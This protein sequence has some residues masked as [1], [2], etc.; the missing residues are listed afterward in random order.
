M[1]KTIIA[2][3]IAL[4]ALA[5]VP[6]LAVPVSTSTAMEQPSSV[7]DV[8]Y[9]RGDRGW[10]PNRRHWDGPGRGYGRRFHGPPPHAR[11]Y[12]RRS[13]DRGYYRY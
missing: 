5:T 3:A 4:G 7:Q 6:A 9:Y 2:A 8:Q 1:R 12:G 10:R 11:A 13:F